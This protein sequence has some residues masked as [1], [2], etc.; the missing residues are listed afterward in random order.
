MQRVKTNFILFY[1]KGIKKRAYI[2]EKDK[3]KRPRVIKK[4]EEQ[5]PCLHMQPVNI[6]T[7]FYL[8]IIP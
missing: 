1:K 3:K 4:A 6:S 7:L 2:I 5:T 8:L